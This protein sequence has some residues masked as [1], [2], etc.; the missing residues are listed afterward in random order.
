MPRRADAG[1]ISLGRTLTVLLLLIASVPAVDSAEASTAAWTVVEVDTPA[2]VVS[3]ARFFTGLATDPSGA[4]AV[5]YGGV[6]QTAAGGDPALADTWTWQD[7]T[8]TPRCGTSEPGA[9]GPCGPGPRVHHALATGPDNVVLFGGAAEQPGGPISAHTDTWLWNGSAW[10][11]VCADGACGPAAELAVAMAGDG[12]RVVLFGGLDIDGAMHYVDDTWVFDGSTW[13]QICG[14]G[15]G[16]PCGP[17]ARAGS[18]LAWDGE[19]FV[20][21]GGGGLGGPPEPSADTWVLDPDAAPGDTWALV[22]G[23]GACGPPARAL[24]GA[25]TVTH[26]RDRTRTGALLAGGAN[27]G[28]PSETQHRDQWLFR[29]GTWVQ[30]PTPWPSTPLELGEDL[31]PGRPVSPSRAPP[32]SPRPARFSSSVSTSGR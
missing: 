25:T 30:L 15:I 12:T 10:I 2:A 27:L 5:L 1:H 20:L 3:S 18:A 29:D 21:F 22:C 8:W 6:P 11:Q 7:G 28:G 13:T 9:T 24:A 4:T 31:P 14:T 16:T 17:S 26:P 23:D 32:V 19:Q